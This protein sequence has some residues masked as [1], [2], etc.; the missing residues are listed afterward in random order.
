M[1]I[2][3]AIGSAIWLAAMLSGQAPDAVKL[4]SASSEER[5]FVKKVI[6]GN[7]KEVEMA[8]NALQKSSS[9]QVK[10]FAQR[11][12]DD[13]SRANE[14]LAALARQKAI[15]PPS[16]PTTGGSPDTTSSSKDADLKG[17]EFDKA[18]MREMVSDH[19]KDASEFEK[20]AKFVK[21][22]DLKAFVDKTLP[23]L[24]DHLKEAR[25][26]SQSLGR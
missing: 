3:F 17:A 18:Y 24:R 4:V 23:T 11:M 1:R 13:H 8:H 19:E 20:A 22:A 25:A 5:E 16:V 9:P 2:F 6:E 26:L 12:V 14:E 10:Q 15:E 21:D 7:Q